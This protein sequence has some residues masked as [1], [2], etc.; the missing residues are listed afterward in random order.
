[1][2]SV[3]MAEWVFGRYGTETEINIFGTFFFPYYE[4]YI[5]QKWNM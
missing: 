1:M 5:A 2:S 4:R 3:V